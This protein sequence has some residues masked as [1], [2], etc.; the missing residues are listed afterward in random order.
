LAEPPLTPVDNGGI[1]QN[2]PDEKAPL[3]IKSKP[4][5]VEG[6]AYKAYYSS[7][8]EDAD[9]DPNER[10]IA[11]QKFAV[12]AP[13]TIPPNQYFVMGD[14]RD[15]SQDSRYWGTVPRDNIVGRALVVYWSQDQSRDANGKDGSDDPL[16]I[17]HRSRWKR[18]GTLIK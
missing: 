9:F 3:V 7:D 15:N 14:N 10:Q 2:A 17:I 6:A 1:M 13:F 5:N 12:G 18:T 4:D 8:T 16:N 11:G